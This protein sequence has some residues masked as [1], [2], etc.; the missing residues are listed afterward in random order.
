M[1]DENQVNILLCEQ[2][3]QRKGFVISGGVGFGGGAAEYCC[4]HNSYF[5]WWL[6]SLERS[7]EPVETTF[8][9]STVGFDTAKSIAYSTNVIHN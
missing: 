5:F 4:Y 3:S 9:V 6:S 2:L 7:G 1:L 8:P